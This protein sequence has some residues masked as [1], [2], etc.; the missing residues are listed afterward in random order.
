LSCLTKLHVIAGPTACGKTAAAIELAKKINGEVIS[1]DSMQVYIG[2]DIGTA[3]PTAEEMDSVPHHLISIVNPD[4]V[5]NV[6][7]FVWRAKN[8]IEDIIKRGKNPIL[9][10]GTGFYI[11]ALIFGADFECQNDEKDNELRLFY[12]N[13]AQEKGNF[14]LHKELQEIDPASAEQIH[15]NNVKRVVRALSYCTSTGLL[16]SEHNKGQKSKAPLYELD[17]RLINIP[18]E[19]LY[20]R[21]NSRVL[22]MWD[23]GLANEVQELLNSGYH[24]NLTA[25]QGIGYKEVVPYLKGETTKEITIENIQQASRNYAK[26]QDTWFRHQ[27]RSL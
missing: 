6:A 20:E 17:L 24:P 22:K 10:G 16:F 5:F 8:V 14:F 18:R 27:L 7:E 15:P 3:K 23:A 13:L 21:I 26:R 1:A 4:E 9:A 25:M 2:M 11:N 19:I 12:A